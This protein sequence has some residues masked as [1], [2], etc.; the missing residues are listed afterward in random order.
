[1]KIEDYRVSLLKRLRDPEYA[2]GYLTEVLANESQS[3]FL[4]A[5]KD[6]MDAHAESISALSSRTGVTRQGVYGALSRSGNPKLYTV[7]QVLGSLGLCL[8]VKRKEA[9]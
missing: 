4:I 9:A 7:R 5:L 3:A 1:M 6:I 8:A 2:A